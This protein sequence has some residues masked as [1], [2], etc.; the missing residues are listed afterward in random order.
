MH[1]AR[2]RA[3]L[4]LLVYG[5]ARISAALAMRGADYDTQGKQSSCRLHEKGGKY[6]VIP[7]HHRAQAWMDAYIDDRPLVALGGPPAGD[8]PPQPPADRPDRRLEDA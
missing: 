1:R 6:L 7:A 2:D 3:L 4:G 8:G 5:L